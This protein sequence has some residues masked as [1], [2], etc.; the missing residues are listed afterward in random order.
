MR[1]VREAHFQGATVTKTPKTLGFAAILLLCGLFAG[2]GLGLWIGLVGIP[3]QL[4][5]RGMTELESKA[6]EDLIVLTANTYAL[7]RDLER[8]K[9]RLAQLKDPKIGER[10][11]TLTKAYAAKNDPAAARLALLAEALG[12]DSPEI[13]ALARTATPTP[14]STPTTTSTPT[15]SRTATVTN[16]PLRVATR[17]PTA[18]RTPAP[19]VLVPPQWIPDFPAGWPGGVKY[20]PVNVAPGQ[21]YWRISRAL[22]CDT[23]DEHDYCNDLPGGSLGTDTYIL[24]TGAGGWRESAPLS[25][26]SSN[27]QVLDVQEK[28]VTDTC[29][30]S[31]SFLSNGYTVQVLGAP[32]DKISGMALYSVKARLSNWHVRYFVTFQLVTR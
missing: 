24:L 4:A 15:P 11:T 14:T 25:V 22:Y 3:M 31:Y 7:D 2:V 21:K 6:Q 28:S 13:A 23:N 27:G 19:A 20:E 29:N 10:T 9:E 17:P 5:N 18:T 8:A 30:C 32:S 26:V 1:L 12:A 16:T